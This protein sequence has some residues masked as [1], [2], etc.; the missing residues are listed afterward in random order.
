MGRLW[1]KDAGGKVHS[2]VREMGLGE[3]N[4]GFGGGIT[5]AAGNGFGQDS[6]DQTRAQVSSGI[7]V[8][9]SNMVT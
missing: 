6:G 4:A 3:A 7:L 8:L 9:S 1:R 5:K 2:F